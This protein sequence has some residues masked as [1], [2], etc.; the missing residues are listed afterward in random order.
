MVARVGHKKGAV[1]T[2]ASA[3]GNRFGRKFQVTVDGFRFDIS[4]LDT[5]ER[6]FSFVYCNELFH[7]RIEPRYNA[8][9][10]YFGN[11]IAFWIHN[12]L[13]RPGPRWVRLPGG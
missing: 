10:G 7:Q 3:K 1:L 6:A 5:M 13:G 12:F 8:F 9:A 11:N 2:T 4:A